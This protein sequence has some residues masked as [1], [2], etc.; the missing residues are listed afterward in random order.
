MA[1]ASVLLALTAIF[2]VSGCISDDP[3][4]SFIQISD[5]PA[6]KPLVDTASASQQNTAQQSVI[7]WDYNFDS[8]LWAP[9]E[10]APECPS[11]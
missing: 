1:K 11:M 3:A 9:A 6:V 8:Y 10:N 2:L 5:E 7:Q 4:K